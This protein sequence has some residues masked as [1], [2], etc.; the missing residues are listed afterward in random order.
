MSWIFT[1]EG[2]GCIDCLCGA[3]QFVIAISEFELNLRCELAEWKSS[4]QRLEYTD[5]F[6]VVA[7]AHGVLCIGVGGSN[8]TRQV[9]LFFIA[10][11]TSRDYGN[12][13]HE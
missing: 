8:I 7:D 12:R 10:R 13:A 4:L 9:E 5:G 6:A 1:N 2:I 11:A 3:V